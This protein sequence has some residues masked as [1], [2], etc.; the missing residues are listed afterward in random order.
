M[1]LVDIEASGLQACFH[2]FLGPASESLTHAAA[3]SSSYYLCNRARNT[4][5]VEAQ[6]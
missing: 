1:I 2:G 6:R 4:L 3:T 5:R